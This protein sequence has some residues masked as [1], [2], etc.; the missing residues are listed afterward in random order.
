MT[1]IAQRIA[2]SCI[3]A[4]LTLLWIIPASAGSLPPGSAVRISDNNAD[5]ISEAPDVAAFGSK[6]YVAW[7][8]T[9]ETPLAT[10]TYAVYFASSDDGGATWSAN[11]RISSP[12]WDGYI[13]YVNVAAGPDEVVWVA[14]LQ[15]SCYSSSGGG[16]CDGETRYNDVRLA[17]SGD[18]GAT[19]GDVTAWDGAD[20]GPPDA[21]ALAVD[22]VTGVGYLFV[23]QANGSGQD[24]VIRRLDLAS[25]TITDV[26]VSG[27]AGN[28]KN[29]DYN[30]PLR[31]V[32]ARNGR[33]CAAWEDRRNNGI[34]GA[35]STDGGLSYNA[36]A[37]WS[38][39]AATQPKLGV[40]PDGT[41][42]LAYQTPDNTIL[43]RRS[44]DAGVS[45]SAP[46]AV[47]LAPLSRWYD[48][49]V[50]ENGAVAIL[51]RAS[52]GFFT[53]LYLTTSSDQGASF[54]TVQVNNSPESV[55]H[56]IPALTTVGSGASTKAVMVW[57]QA[58]GSEHEIFAAVAVQDD[59]PPT[60]PTNVQ[61]SAG[62]G[63][64][65]LTWSAAGDANGIRGY[66]IFR[67]A[68]V[69]GPFQPINALLVTGRAYRDV[70]LSPGTYFYRVQAVDGAGNRGPLSAVVSA[71]PTV[72]SGLSGLNGRIV[73]AADGQAHVRTLPGLGAV[74]S[75]LTGQHP[76]LSA[77]G[78]RVFFKRSTALMARTLNNG[79]E[80]TLTQDGSLSGEPFGVSADG[81]RFVASYRKH[82]TQYGNPA[83]CFAFEPRVFVAGS[84][85]PIRTI[86]GI[87]AGEPTL[88]PDGRWLAYLFAGRCDNL[89]SSVVNPPQLCLRHLES[90]AE[91]CHEGGLRHPDFSPDGNSLV[92]T[93]PF[94]G[95]DEIWRAALGADGSL[96]AFVQLTRGA[97]GEISAEPAWSSDGSWVIF[98]RDVDAG[99]GEDWRLFVVRG[100]GDSLR[101]L[102]IRG[103]SP[104][105]AGGG[106]AGVNPTLTERIYLPM[107]RR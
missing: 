64:V 81:R 107:V 69:N 100:D 106:P 79:M 51:W 22:G 49:T 25:S 97:V 90:G 72:G 8:D 28:G 68:G 60:A 20:G 1:S 101:A 63:S 96:G 48:L 26:T 7:R 39:G 95:Q 54:S 73:F 55:E 19:F 47:T 88:S 76:L 91:K 34:Y 98:Q 57:Q 30:G 78:G 5:G 24:M 40:A 59:I 42:W 70:G 92:F 89:V 32:A 86:P 38:Q 46:V 75:P 6:V 29:G 15:R 85:T 56:R 58:S 77:D 9:R 12:S 80:E 84:S 66:H 44:T 94:S 102:G 93:A 27:G 43:V 71:S 74:G 82:Y 10:L 36:D 67:S 53:D 83:G 35:C 45:W 23:Q 14:W 4:L 16:E 103:T 13:D 18:G 31:S 104:D 41:V 87:V 99:A 2:P 11:R 52:R 37:A 105:W 3:L 62:D 33:V 17:L 50:N 65:L 61:A 21:V